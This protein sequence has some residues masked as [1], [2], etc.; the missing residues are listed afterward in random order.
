PRHSTTKV[1]DAMN[2]KIHVQKHQL[3]LVLRHGDLVRVIE[4]G[5]AFVPG[6]FL[7]RDRVLVVDTLDTLVRLHRLEALLLDPTFAA[8]VHVVDVADDQRALVWKDGRL[9]YV[10]PPGRHAVWKQPA[11][12]EIEVFD[13]RQA[14]FEH[15]RLD[16]LVA[17]DDAR[18]Y[19]VAR[20]VGTHERLLVFVDGELFE[21]VGAG[22]HAYWQLQ[23]RV[24]FRGI[25]L[26]EDVLDVAG[27]EIMTSDRV[28]LRVTL[29]VTIRVVDPVRAATEVADHRQL[30][31]RDAQ[32]ALRS[33]VGARTLDELLVSKDGVGEEVRARIAQ[34]AAA[35]GVAVGSVG[36]RDVVL[37]GDMK[38]I[39]NQVIQARKEA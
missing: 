2:L 4:P 12:V 7:G 14:R 34:S 1:A 37:P 33:A 11:E 5:S 15:P 13:V 6:R 26:R 31:Y 35:A 9:A 21:D 3:G 36:V 20:R 16:A 25:D 18:R 23:E 10:L 17:H 32:L 29:V 30:V 38:D 24:T 22:L 19:L 27:Q 8:L 28:T 39:L